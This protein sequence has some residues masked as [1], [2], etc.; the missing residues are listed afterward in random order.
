MKNTKSM[1][2][3]VIFTTVFLIPLC[4]QEGLGSEGVPFEELQ[5][6]IDQQTQDGAFA[7]QEL[8][9]Q[10]GSND[11]D[12]SNLQEQIKDLQAQIDGLPVPEPPNVYTNIGEFTIPDESKIVEAE[13]LC[14]SGDIA[15]GGG[16][17]IAYRTDSDGIVTNNFE[18]FVSTALFELFTPVGWRI[19]GTTS[20]SAGSLR[21]VVQCLDIALPKF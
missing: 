17:I 3:A 6:Q 19:V 12:I 10:I 5:D 1:F 21:A 13:V 20:K 7:H 4:A 9:D 8:Q 14:D 2:M 11:I 18:A 16:H 15:T